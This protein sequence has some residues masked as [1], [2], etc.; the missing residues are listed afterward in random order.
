M[1]SE[2]VGKKVFDFIIIYG[3]SL[4]ITVVNRALLERCDHDLDD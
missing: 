4:W 1:S 2:P 3:G